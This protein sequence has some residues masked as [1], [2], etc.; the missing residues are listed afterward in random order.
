LE[1]ERRD[2]WKSGVDQNLMALNAAQRVADRLVNDL[3]KKYTSIDKTLRGD[4][5]LDTDGITARMHTLENTVNLLRAEL[6]A[7]KG[8]LSGEIRALKNTVDGD[9]AG[10]AGH[11]QRIDVL[12]GKRKDK[13]KRAGYFWHFVGVTATGSVMVTGWMILNWEHVEQFAAAVWRHIHPA[14]VV[15]VKAAPKRVKHH[16]PKAAA[17]PEVHDEPSPEPDAPK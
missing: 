17:V 2:D 13:D 6:K 12:E 3:V 11:E 7:S 8:E 14:P 1:N 4:S 5:E 10:N 9:M 16:R 15:T